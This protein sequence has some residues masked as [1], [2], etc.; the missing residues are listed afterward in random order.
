ME[1]RA[2]FGDG[3]F[4]DVSFAT[5]QTNPVNTVADS[6][7]RLGLT[8]TD[9]AQARV[10]QWA[11]EHR[12]GHRGTHHYAADAGP[13]GPGPGGGRLDRRAAGP[14]FQP[15][16][17][18]RSAPHVARGEQQMFVTPESVA[19]AYREILRP[20]VE[21]LRRG[22]DSGLFS[23][24]DPDGEALSIHGVVWANIERHWATT[25]RDPSEIRERVQRFC[26]RGLGVP[27]ETV[28][29][30]LTDVAGSRGS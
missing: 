28:A 17:S 6:H 23:G 14:G 4:V 9:S 19:P 22:R 15:A 26:L 16:D 8:F 3:R 30:V 25:H 13:L 11:D 7:D 2:K 20:L 27:P 29:A 5:L 12:P 10:R 1:F 21:Q 24:I 18:L